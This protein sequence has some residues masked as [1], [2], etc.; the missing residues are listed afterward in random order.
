MKYLLYLQAAPGEM[1][2]GA[3]RKQA[4][5]PGTEVSNL[6]QRSAGTEVTYNL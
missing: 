2:A 1:A 4:S 6:A 5:L 3:L